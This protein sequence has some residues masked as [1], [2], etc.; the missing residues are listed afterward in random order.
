MSSLSHRVLNSSCHMSLSLL[1][2]SQ[3]P[4]VHSHRNTKQ[5]Q[6]ETWVALTSL[7]ATPKILLSGWQGTQYLCLPPHHRQ[8]R[9]QGCSF[10]LPPPNQLW[11]LLFITPTCLL[12]VF[13]SL[14]VLLF[15]LNPAD[16]LFFSQKMSIW[17]KGKIY[18]R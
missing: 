15:C 10:M 14:K 1:L 3:R 17:T 6:R 5:N 7:I 18:H 4:D 12:L 16:E 13:Y 2:P 9:H 8:Q 11:F